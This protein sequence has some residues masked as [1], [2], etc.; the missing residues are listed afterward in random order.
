MQEPIEKENR[1]APV[2]RRRS[3]VIVTICVALAVCILTAGVTLNFAMMYMARNQVVVA[4]SDYQLLDMIKGMF[5]SY[6][7]EGQPDD[8]DLLLGAA[9]GMVAASG[10]RYAQYYT[11]ED[12][13]AFLE[14]Q[15]GNYVGIGV[16]VQ[17]DPE[18]GSVM[19][20]HVIENSPAE[21]S[22]VMV[23]DIFLTVEDEDVT[24]TDITTLSEM[25]RGEAETEV[26]ISV[27]H[28]DGTSEEMSITRRAVV[29]DR[30]TSKMVA[31]NIGYVQITQFAGNAA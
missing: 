21:E 18:T 12:Y 25:V 17:Q 11:A 13:A 19:V 9:H 6:G 7:L 27:L 23:G 3:A 1:Q 28:S 14:D 30:V 26:R 20:T 5:A 31:E 15:S 16:T 10:D 29:E 4:D 2:V 22:G 8:E 24:Q